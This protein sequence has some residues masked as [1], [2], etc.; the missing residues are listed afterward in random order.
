MC[1][2]CLFLFKEKKVDKE[3][4]GFLVFG[5]FI[6]GIWRYLLL[7]ILLGNK[8]EFYLLVF[9]FR[10][11]IKWLVYSIGFAYVVNVVRNMVGIFT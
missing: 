4:R 8:G 5:C 3:D 2:G 7:D 9:E 1:C 10:K 11:F 6:F